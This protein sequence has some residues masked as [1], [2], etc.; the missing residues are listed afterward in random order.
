M[1]RLSRSW[2][3]NVELRFQSTIHRFYY[4]C[5]LCTQSC[6]HRPDDG[7]KAHTPGRSQLQCKLCRYSTVFDL[8]LSCR[9]APATMG[10]GASP[11]LRAALDMVAADH[12]RAP[13]ARHAGR[14]SK[15]TTAFAAEA[16]EQAPPH[17][18]QPV[19]ERK[20]DC[21]EKTWTQQGSQTHFCD[22]LLGNQ[23]VWQIIVSDNLS[24]PPPVSAA[25]FTGFCASSSVGENGLKCG[26]GRV[27]PSAQHA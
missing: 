14:I 1:L 12:A 24:L 5:I 22:I 16:L 27:L 25:L 7:L 20:S 26:K 9:G 11:M 15:W 18:R 13:R 3:G 17:A 19:A 23:W 10:I 6:S 8:A 2:D 4:A 21:R